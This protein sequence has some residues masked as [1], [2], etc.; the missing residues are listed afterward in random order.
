MKIKWLK[1]LSVLFLSILMV[2]G[3][4]AANED[5]NNDAPGVDE[6]DTMNKDDEKDK[7]RDPEDPA[8]DPE[9]MG[10]RDRKDE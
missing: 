5:N 8:E 3:C 6:N 9:D 10:D 4:N 2:T 1:I 7:E